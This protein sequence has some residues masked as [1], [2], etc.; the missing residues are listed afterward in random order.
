MPQHK[1]ARAVQEFFP[2]GDEPFLPS[3]DQ[4]SSDWYANRVYVIHELKRLDAERERRFSE[5][6]AETSEIKSDL[7]ELEKEFTVLRATVSN[8]AG[9][10]A[11]W[12]M[13]GGALVTA[14]LALLIYYLTGQPANANDLA[15]FNPILLSL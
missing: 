14:I 7:K 10:N 1:H 6:K 2:A 15:L 9:R 12:G 11:V 4:S 5:V 3:A 13:I 8:Q